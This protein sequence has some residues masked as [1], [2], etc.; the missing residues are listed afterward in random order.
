MIINYDNVLLNIY[1]TTYDDDYYYIS[2]YCIWYTRTLSLSFP[3][4][5]TG[6]ACKQKK[7]SRK[8]CIKSHFSASKKAFVIKIYNP[9]F[10]RR[11]C[12]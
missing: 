2:Y 3:H 12:V 1:E 7:I 8:V 11:S 6:I 10:I 5:H 4:T 9:H